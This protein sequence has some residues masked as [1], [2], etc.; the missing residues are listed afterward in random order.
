MRDGL[1]PGGLTKSQLATMVAE[2]DDWWDLP[3]V[4]SS[5]NNA[6]SEPGKS[7]SLTEKL[8]VFAFVVMRRAGRLRVNEDGG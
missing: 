2:M 8:A 4:R 7:L 1:A 6:L 3:A 5:L